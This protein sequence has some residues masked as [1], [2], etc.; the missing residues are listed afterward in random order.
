M[1]REIAR[2]VARVTAF[3]LLVSLGGC[4][5][6]TRHEWHR[7]DATVAMRKIDERDC[8]KQAAREVGPPPTAPIKWSP[9]QKQIRRQQTDGCGKKC[10]YSRA[11]DE[12]NPHYDAAMSAYNAERS[13]YDS[14]RSSA[15]S[16]CMITLGYAYREIPEK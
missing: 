7:E 10:S 14:L 9:S 15:V 1:D 11:E 4:G 12:A 13:R 6:F 2:R 8:R 3:L 16:N 5:L